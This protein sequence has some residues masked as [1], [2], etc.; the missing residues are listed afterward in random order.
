MPP[1]LAAAAAAAS[2]GEKRIVARSG[3]KARWPQAVQLALCGQRKSHLE[4]RL[5]VRQ[6]R[7]AIL[8]G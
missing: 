3:R 5:I 4:H 2:T 6:R 8:D 1:V 7:D